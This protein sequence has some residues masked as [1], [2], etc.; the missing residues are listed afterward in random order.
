MKSIAAVVMA[1]ILEM[2]LVFPAYAS[3]ESPVIH[4][5]AAYLLDVQSG[6]MLYSKNGD[7]QL[8]PASTTKIMTALLA[9]EQGHLQDTVTAGPT[10]LNRQEVYG[11]Q[12]YL[13]QGEHMPLKDLLYAI[14]LNSANDAAVAVAEHVGGTLSQFIEMMNSRA[15]EIGMTRTHFVNSTG[16]NA[17]GHVTTAHDL[18][19]LARVAYQNPTF[20][21][22]TRTKTQPIPRTTPNTPVLMVNENRLLA[23]DSDVNGMKTGYTSQAQNCLVASAERN[24]RQV[25]GVILKSPGGEMFS[26]M[27]ALLN[28]G[29]ENFETSVYQK[30]GSRFA[31]L[32]VG[33]AEVG[34]VSATDI[35]RTQRRGSDAPGLKMTLSN[36]RK[37]LDSVKKGEKLGQVQV[38]EGGFLLQRVDLLAD[39]SVDPPEKTRSVSGYMAAYVLAALLTVI[40]LLAFYRAY[41]KAARFKQNRQRKRGEPSP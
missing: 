23:R 35:Y 30:A 40:T 17:E 4:G 2:M 15:A 13:A 6:Q 8:P 39:H 7:E 33:K 26:D 28:Y 21:S 36:L 24:G 25:V 18:A 11:T 14:L 22:Y 9:L 19:L 1:L 41:L 16:L 12:I 20:L 29:F 38:W 3:G 32:P 34:L 37:G 27:Q 10:L 5:E 31:S